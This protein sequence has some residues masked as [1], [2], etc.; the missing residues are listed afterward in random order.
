LI[1]ANPSG[2]VGDYV[3]VNEVGAPDVLNYNWDNDEGFWLPMRLP[4]TF[5]TTRMNYRKEYSIYIIRQHVFGGSYRKASQ[6]SRCYTPSTAPNDV[7]KKFNYHQTG[8]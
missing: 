3:Q 1:A 2:S 8:N 7:Q 6:G 4:G 5:P